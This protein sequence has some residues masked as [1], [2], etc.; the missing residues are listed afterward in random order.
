MRREGD[1]WVLGGGLQ[2]LFDMAKDQAAGTVNAR[3]PKHSRGTIPEAGTGH[4]RHQQCGSATTEP[5]L[6]RG[7]RGW[8][9]IISF[10][11]FNFSS[12]KN[13]GT[14]DQTNYL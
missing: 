10:S 7:R 2:T 5:A 9:I 4:R 13:I 12:Q 3:A 14:N 8:E 6:H 1:G 11:Q